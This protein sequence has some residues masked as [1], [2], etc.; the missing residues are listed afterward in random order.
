MFKHFIQW[1]VGLFQPTT[2]TA[3]W[4]FPVS[5]E[6]TP[7]DDEKPKR[8]RKPAVKK[9]PVKKIVAVIKKKPTV[10]KAKA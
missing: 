6:A 5:K 9:A 8:K 1:A 7:C 10:K 2:V 3:Q 4:D